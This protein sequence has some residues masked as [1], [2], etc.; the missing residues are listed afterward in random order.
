[1]LGASTTLNIARKFAQPFQFDAELLNDQADH[2]NRFMETV[3]HLL[4]NRPQS[5]FFPSKLFL[6]KLPPPL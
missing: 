4:P 3:A 2:P 6:Q 5:R 1:M